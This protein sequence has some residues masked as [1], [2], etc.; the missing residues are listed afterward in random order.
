MALTK[1]RFSQISQVDSGTTSK[2]DITFDDNLI[3]CNAKGDS[4]S[5]VGFIFNRG[6]NLKSAIVWDKSASAFVLARTDLVG[7]SA[8]KEINIVN[9]ESLHLQDLL[10][11]G[12]VT[13]SGNLT[14]TGSVISTSIVGEP[15]PMG[16]Q[17]IQ[18][19]PGPQGIPGNDGASGTGASAVAQVLSGTIPAMSG[20]ALIPSDNTTPLSTEGTLL[21]TQSITPTTATSRV[22]IMSSVFV[23]SGTANR[24]I[25]MAIFRG[26]TCIHAQVVNVTS[27][28]RPMNLTINFVDHPN[29]TSAVTYTA[30]VGSN[31]SATWYINNNSSSV[32]YGGASNSD[33][34]IMEYV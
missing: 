8:T 20:T 28:G 2:A 22:G 24:N 31:S 18:G 25:T 14:V 11:S 33:Y 13:I 4:S 3:L 32:R 17:G 16:P 7:T 10:S 15:G 23:D 12:N 19:V 30:R 9:Y 26:T 1:P 21:W 5:D 29:T 6:A 34:I 27:V